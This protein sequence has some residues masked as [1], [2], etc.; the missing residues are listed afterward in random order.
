M[1]ADG[2]TKPLPRPAFE[3]KQARIG[4]VDVGGDY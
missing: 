3:D 4:V 2:F 1:L